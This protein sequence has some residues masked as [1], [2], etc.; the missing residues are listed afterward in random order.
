[1]PGHTPSS[2]HSSCQ[3]AL[4]VADQTS[5]SPPVFAKH[6]PLVATFETPLPLALRPPPVQLTKTPAP[7]R[8]AIALNVRHC[9]YLI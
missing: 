3:A 6:V 2:A 1:M 5:S 8:S 7:H 4:D 9:V